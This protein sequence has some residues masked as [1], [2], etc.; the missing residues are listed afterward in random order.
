MRRIATAVFCLILWSPAFA[1]DL[2]REQTYSGGETVFSTG[3]NEILIIGNRGLGYS[4]HANVY[5]PLVGDSITMKIDDDK[6]QEYKIQH[7]TGST[8]LVS[9]SIADVSK[10]ASA[11]KIQISKS[12]CAI[13]FGG[14][15]F[16]RK[17]TLDSTE[18]VFEA[19]LSEQFKHYQE[20]I[21]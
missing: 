10:V 19:P 11:K 16:T 14:C 2:W 18:W 6:P 17:G 13:S 1:Y 21:R 9:A 20:K 7:I 12:R 15:T 8:Y 3:V 4:I 5:G